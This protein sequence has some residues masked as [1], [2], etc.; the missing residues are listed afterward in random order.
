MVGIGVDAVT[1]EGMRLLNLPAS[2]IHS[3]TWMAP[4]F[5]TRR[6]ALIR[7]TVIEIEGLFAGG[8]DP[9]SQAG[10]FHVVVLDEPRAVRLQR[11]YG[12]LVEN[13]VLDGGDGGGSG[14][15]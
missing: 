13:E 6:P 10:R 1:Q 8:L 3:E 5:P 4:E 15:A 12:A 14:H 7:Q 11:L 9:A 2:L